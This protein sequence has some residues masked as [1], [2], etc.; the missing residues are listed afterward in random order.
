LKGVHV[1]GQEDQPRQRIEDFVLGI[2]GHRL[3]GGEERIPVGK[4]AAENDL[5]EHLLGRVVIVCDVAHEE[6]VDAEQDVE[7]EQR[8]DERENRC[9]ER[10]A[11]LLR[12]WRR[13]VQNASTS[14]VNAE[15]AAPMAM[16]G[17]R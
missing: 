4:M 17:L 11:R 16:S 6:A 15:I 3:T 14:R 1:I 5:A 12:H 10:T 2:R 8:R 9:D 13:I 7:E